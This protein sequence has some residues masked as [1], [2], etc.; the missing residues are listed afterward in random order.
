[1]NEDKQYEMIF[2]L[3]EDT[4]PDAL[5]N[6]VFDLR[7]LP[8]RNTQ[9][10]DAGMM[11]VSRRNQKVVEKFAPLV[12]Y[13][14]TV[15]KFN[16]SETGYADLMDVRNTHEHAV[17]PLIAVYRQRKFDNY[18]REYF[19]LSIGLSGEVFKEDIRPSAQFNPTH[20][21]ERMVF[22]NDSLVNA[23]Y[24]D[25]SAKVEVIAPFQ[26]ETLDR[27]LTNA[28]TTPFTFLR[29]GKTKPGYLGAPHIAGVYFVPVPIEYDISFHDSNCSMMGWFTQKELKDVI[30]AR[31]GLDAAGYHDR[32]PDTARFQDAAMQNRLGPL[33]HTHFEPWSA[34]LIMDGSGE[35]AHIVNFVTPPDNFR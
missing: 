17:Q 27:I 2:G 9:I 33:V 12:P 14:V 19:V 22:I 5:N 28:L 31:E 13:G 7:L 6:K 8:S 11:G 25:Y 26:E 3:H 24:R 10:L 23:A 16:G 30:A 21:S 29:D 20:T 34:S 1:M 35:F 18:A 15:K 32:V 4:I